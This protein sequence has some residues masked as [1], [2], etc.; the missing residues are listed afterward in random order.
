VVNITFICKNWVRTMLR[1][2]YICLILAVIEL[3]LHNTLGIITGVTRGVKE[4]MA[5]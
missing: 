5:I 2:V 4:D 3:Y 1:R